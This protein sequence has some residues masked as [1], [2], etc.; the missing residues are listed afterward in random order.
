MITILLLFR[1]NSERQV[2][3]ATTSFQQIRTGS[4]VDPGF[5]CTKK[6]KERLVCP[7]P[8]LGKEQCSKQSDVVRKQTGNCKA[9]QDTAKSLQTQFT[10]GDIFDCNVV[11]TKEKN[12]KNKNKYSLHGSPIR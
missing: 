8:E 12:K 10:S 9:A 1:V 4:E 7:A 11:I 3:L 2:Q 5:T 6:R